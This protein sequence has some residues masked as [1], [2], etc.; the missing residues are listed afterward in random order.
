MA[1]IS[2]PCGISNDIIEEKELYHQIAAPNKR[3][4]ELGAHMHTLENEL[5]E[6][7]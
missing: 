7:Q 6:R 4:E 5:K 3:H 2:C 1:D